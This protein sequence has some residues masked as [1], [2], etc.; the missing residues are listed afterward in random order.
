MT[1]LLPATIAEYFG[2][3]RAAACGLSYAG[4]TLGAFV[5]PLIFQQLLEVFDLNT[6]LLIMG[7]ITMNGILGAIFLAPLKPPPGLSSNYARI[8]RKLSSAE[9]ADNH[10]CKSFPSDSD[11]DEDADVTLSGS[12]DHPVTNEQAISGVPNADSNVSPAE[13]AIS[14]PK[15]CTNHNDL[16]EMDSK[17]SHRKTSYDIAIDDQI[18]KNDL[19]QESTQEPQSLYQMLSSQMAKD[20]Q[21][22]SN[23]YFHLVSFTY[24]S[25]IMANVTLMIILPD[26]AKDSGLSETHAIFL[27]SLFSVTDLMGRLLPGWI[28]FYTKQVIS[29]KI[30][31]IFSITMMG[32]LLF[33]FPILVR[34]ASV[35]DMRPLY[36]NVTITEFSQL[37]V[38]ES[39]I[40]IRIIFIVLTLMC[41]FVSG[42][43]MILPPVVISEYLGSENTAVAFGLSNFICGILT[44]TRPIIIGF[45]KSR[46][47]RYDGVF[48]LFGSFALLSGILWLLEMMVSNGIKERK[49]SSS[50]DNNKRI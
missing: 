25:Y 27:L 33:M 45:I 5:F 9:S 42:C 13:S 6:C 41:G 16:I 28:S 36:N 38:E 11:D 23:R 29:N 49:S 20:A 7:A 2:P 34:S 48:F 31:Y 22:L 47:K 44:F 37:D 10:S 1:G 35:I 21:L 15:P 12:V 19:K 50:N 17:S 26:F 40:Q 8:D 46:T 14:D 4:A 3:D 39:I 32:I 43:Q 24:I 30:I 18:I